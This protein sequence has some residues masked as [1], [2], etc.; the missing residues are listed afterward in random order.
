[1]L[2]EKGKQSFLFLRY[3]CSIYGS[4]HCTKRKSIF[5]SVY[6]R[7]MMKKIREK[8]WNGWKSS[9]EKISFPSFF[10]FQP[11]L[12]HATL[13]LLL[14]RIDI[15]TIHHSCNDVTHYD[16]FVCCSLAEHIYCSIDKFPSFPPRN[17][18]FALLWMFTRNGR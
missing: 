10:P 7:M 3:F 17:A 16:M 15:H 8:L 2:V 5:L 1:M 13:R 11:T 12:I 14:F 18:F 9:V 4:E 6:T